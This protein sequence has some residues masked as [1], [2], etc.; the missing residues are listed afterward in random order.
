MRWVGLGLAAVIVLVSAVT[1]VVPDRRIAFELT[2]MNRAGFGVIAAMR[3]AIALIL[4]FAAP[5]SRE[6]R[7]IRAIGILVL[8]AGLVTPW[9]ATDSGQ[10][11][12]NQL[13]SAGPTVMRISAIVGL[14]LG[15]F[16]VYALR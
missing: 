3:I 14:A 8:V 6:P 4:V 7:I 12:V 9:F 15:G 11:I 5:Q 1:L 16:L 2:L 10:A 13:V